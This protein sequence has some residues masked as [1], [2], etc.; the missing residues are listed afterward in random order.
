MEIMT[1]GGFSR[2][3]GPTTLPGLD[4][5]STVQLLYHLSLLYILHPQKP[6][7]DPTYNKEI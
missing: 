5:H 1:V 4:Q 6:L 3:F 2:T 7:I